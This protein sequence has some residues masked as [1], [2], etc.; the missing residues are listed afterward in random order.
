MEALPGHIRFVGVDDDN[1]DLF[2][3]QYAVTNGISY[4][5]Y[6]IEDEKTA[7]VDSVDRRM[8][9][10]WLEKIGL[11]LGDKTP[12]Y[13]IVNHVEPDHSGSIGALLKAYP[14]IRVVATAKAVAML[15]NFFEDVDF[16]ARAV[17][18]GR[19]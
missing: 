14:G 7:I 18:V 9:G 6:L 12:D 2:E 16:A 15:G 5:S 3:G 4:N 10:E 11:A 17:T 1:I 8:C 13:I 19:K